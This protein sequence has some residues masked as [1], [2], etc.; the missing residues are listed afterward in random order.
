VSSAFWGAFLGAGLFFLFYSL[1][2]NAKGWAALRGNSPLILMLAAGV[3][4]AA[5]IAWGY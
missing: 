5:F 3:G 2:P 1:R 4:L